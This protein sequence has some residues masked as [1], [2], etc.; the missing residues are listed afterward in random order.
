M[1][2][3][4]APFAPSLFQGLRLE[5]SDPLNFQFLLEDGE[6]SADHS[7]IERMLRYFMAALALPQKDVWV[8]LSPGESRRVAPQA[9]ALTEIGR[10]LLGQDYVLKQLAASLLFPESEG[11]RA[12]WENVYRQAWIRFGTVDIPLETQSRVWIVPGEISLYQ[13]KGVVLVASARLQ[14]LAEDDYLRFKDG[15]PEGSGQSDIRRLVSDVFRQMILPELEREVNS[16]PAFSRLRQVYYA[17]ILADWYKKNFQMIS[18]LSSYVDQGRLAGLATESPH[19]REQVWGQYMQ[20]YQIGVFNFVREESSPDG[21]QIPRKYFSGGISLDVAANAEV[22]DSRELPRYARPLRLVN[23]QAVDRAQVPEEYLS[24]DPR[25]AGNKGRNLQALDSLLPDIVPPF[26]VISGHLYSAATG[27][28]QMVALVCAKVLERLERVLRSGATLAVRPAGYINMPGILPTIKQVRTHQELVQAVWDIYKAWE[29]PEVRAYLSTETARLEAALAI[30]KKFPVDIGPAIVVQQEVFSDRG[31][32]SGS[33]VFVS[34][35]IKSGDFHVSGSLGINVVPEDIRNGSVRSLLNLGPS[36]DEQFPSFSQDGGA[37][38]YATL[39]SAARKLEKAYHFPVEVEFVVERGKLWVLQVNH[40]DIPATVGSQILTRMVSEGILSR[41]GTVRERVRMIR[42]RVGKIRS[43]VNLEPLLENVRGLSVGAVDGV[44]SFSVPEAKQMR[45]LGQKVI[46]LSLEPDLPGVTQALIDAQI[47]GFV[48]MYG[49]YHMHNARLARNRLIP[50]LSLVGTSAR[51]VAGVSAPRLQIG[52][53]TYSAGDRLVVNAE[54][55]NRDGEVFHSGGL[56]VNDQEES[57][58]DYHEEAVNYLDFDEQQVR[59]QVRQRFVGQDYQVLTALHA[60]LK[61]YLFLKVDPQDFT[62]DQLEIATNELHQILD[63]AYRE[64][65]QVAESADYN[66]AREAVFVPIVE[67]FGDSFPFPEMRTLGDLEKGWELMAYFVER[68][69]AMPPARID[70]FNYSS[71]RPNLVAESL[72]IPLSFSVLFNDPEHINWTYENAQLW[73]LVR[74]FKPEISYNKDTLAGNFLSAPAIEGLRFVADPLNSSQIRVSGRADVLS[75]SPSRTFS[76]MARD[77]L[78]DAW[79]RKVL[80]FAHR[81]VLVDV[82]DFRDY[83]RHRSEEALSRYPPLR[84]GKSPSFVS[85]ESVA[86]MLQEF[87]LPRTYQTAALRSLKGGDFVAEDEPGET[88]DDGYDILDGDLL[89]RLSQQTLGSYFVGEEL[90]PGI[91][92]PPD[93]H[94]TRESRLLLNLLREVFPS[95][96]LIHRAGRRREQGFMNHNLAT[97]ETV[98]YYSWI[99]LGEEVV[100]ELARELSGLALRYDLSRAVSVE[101]QARVLDLEGLLFLLYLDKNKQLEDLQALDPVSPVGGIDLSLSWGTGRDSLS[102][103]ESAQDALV[104]DLDNGLLIKMMKVCF[105]PDVAA[106][107]P[108][109]SLKK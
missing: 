90:R 91:V 100:G 10:E 51:I 29:M 79:D 105:L 109:F 22:T 104:P 69:R 83:I 52:S 11:G 43:G 66:G 71:E 9:L 14:V 70:Y 96:R 74:H 26:L 89:W 25:S 17:L 32:Y 108:D 64:G 92:R 33:G 35:N 47:D 13:Q 27:D 56:F 88:K 93:P 82:A 2:L 84:R 80:F 62:V 73:A 72:S 34:R 85:E 97:V 1:I 106:F 39:E 16:G 94:R 50:G 3:P 23:V 18:G 60:L 49:D 21:G 36:V 19:L 55:F 86:E 98:H 59:Q 42:Q 76:L 15:K 61:A 31:A 5:A 102:A 67:G 95:G 54:D 99:I 78:A 37:G 58:I 103:V 6:S 63:E 81:E 40:Q 41:A 12:F 38:F 20:A 28:P 87:F 45:A 24:A 48:T 53:R 75:G 68:Y 8:N 107:I 44:L 46:L 30:D 101:E 77:P 57:V 4:G 7:E 65:E